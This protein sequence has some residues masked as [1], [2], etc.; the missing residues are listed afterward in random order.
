MSLIFLWGA[1]R[2]KE[3]RGELKTPSRHT[4]ITNRGR[5]GEGMGSRGGRNKDGRP[6]KKGIEQMSGKIVFG[7]CT[8]TN[9]T[10]TH[11]YAVHSH[12]QQSLY[13][14]PPSADSHTR[15]GND[16]LGSSFM[17][18]LRLNLYLLQRHAYTITLPPRNTLLRLYTQLTYPE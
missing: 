10:V 11:L 14:I 8:L 2:E 17:N 12:T 7:L 6:S 13:T 9:S 1:E 3:L 16:S 18:Y 15:P 4:E 5:L